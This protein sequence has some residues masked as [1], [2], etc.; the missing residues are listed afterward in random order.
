MYDSRS[1][2]APR[3]IASLG[4]PAGFQTGRPCRESAITVGRSVCFIACRQ[5][6]AVSLAPAGR[7][8]S[9]FGVARSDASCS[10][11]WCVGPSSP[12]PIESCV[13]TNVD[14]IPISAARRIDAFM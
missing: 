1:T 5:A 13:K 4:T 2:Y 3:S 7:T 14:G 8:T 10:I 12:S 6:S 9:T 11:G